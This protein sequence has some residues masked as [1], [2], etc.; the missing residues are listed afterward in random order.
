MRNSGLRSSIQSGVVFV[1]RVDLPSCGGRLMISR[2][3][4]PSA[5]STMAASTTSSAGVCTV[6]GS[7]AAASSPGVANRARACSRWAA[8]WRTL[9]ARSSLSF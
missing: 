8:R 2:S 3:Q 9:S 4:R 6:V 7:I 5:T 1:T